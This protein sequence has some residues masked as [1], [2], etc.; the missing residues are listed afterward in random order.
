MNFDELI[1]QYHWQN[2]PV[3]LSG[4]RTTDSSLEICD[5]D[6][7]IFDENSPNVETIQHKNDFVKIHH[8][9]LSET[10]SKI[11][12]QYDDMQIIQDESWDL[13][14]LLSKIKEKRNILYKDYAKNSLLESIFCC[15][16][17]KQGIKESSIFAPCW[18]KSASFFLA[19]GIMALNQMKSGSCHML[20][21]M[22]KFEKNPINEKISVVNE[23]VGIERATPSLLQRMLKSTIGYSEMINGADSSALIQQKHDY[24]ISNSM[25]SDCYF[26]LGYE[27]K[28]NFVKLKDSIEKKPDL[29]H[30]LKIAFDIEADLNL[31]QQQANLVQKSSN[32]I[33]EYIARR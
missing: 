18:Q 5:Y 22:R 25:L 16:K 1:S 13:R 32:E 14:M 6:L 29:I 21:V 2:Y 26:Y 10:Q 20:D 33:L 4:C 9:S 28:E 11:L 19:D 30:V 3:G 23:T 27:T 15:E 24:F 17:A 12:V 7:T 31:L 8:G